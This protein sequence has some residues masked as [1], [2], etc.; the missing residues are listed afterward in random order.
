[1]ASCP[2]C[3]RPVALARATCLYCGATLPHEGV[4]PAL[5]ASATPPPS[6]AGVGGPSAGAGEGGRL[7]V[8]LDL[9]GLPPEALARALDLPPYEAG[10][11]VKRGGLHLHRVLE[12]RA[13][14]A[15]AERLRASGLAVLLAPE[16]EARVRPLR[17]VGG[18]RGEGVL[19]L[20][21]EEGPLT[22]HRGGVALVVRGAITREYLPP[23]RR[24][25]VDTAR[26]EPGYRVHLHQRHEPRAVELDAFAFEFGVSVSGSARLELDAWVGE[27]APDATVDD[28]FRRLAPALGPA[29]AE[30]RGALAAAGS[31]ALGTR[32]RRG[33]G[34]DETPVVLDNVEQFRIYSG[35]RAAVERRR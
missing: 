9:A 4:S 14:V 18:E 33:G 15:E 1:M 10:L 13:A 34:G 3:R 6:A 16:A 23:S 5:P 22:L 12:H 29:G 20:R 8:A 35:W 19:A 30:P 32:G 17:A 11:L 7:V 31:L 25:R 26:L 27:I 28:G 24:R 2:A 21:T